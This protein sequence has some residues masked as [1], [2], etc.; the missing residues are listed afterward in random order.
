MNY[1]TLKQKKNFLDRKIKM[2]EP[3]ENTGKLST[4][5]HFGFELFIPLYARSEK[6]QPHVNKK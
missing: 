6:T 4:F 3:Y 1:H 2:F 5:R